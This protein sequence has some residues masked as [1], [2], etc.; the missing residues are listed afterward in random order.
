MSS[1]KAALESDTR[2]LA[3]EAGRKHQVR[4]NTISAGPLG[5]R[6]AK[7]IGFID[8]MIRWAYHPPFPPYKCCSCCG[9]LQSHSKHL[10]PVCLSTTR[11]KLQAE[12][13]SLVLLLLR[14]P[15]RGM[16][17]ATC[18]QQCTVRVCGLSSIISLLYL[19][20][21]ALRKQLAFACR[22]LDSTQ[23]LCHKSMKFTCRYSYENA[24]IQ[25]ELQA[26]EVGNAAAFLLSPLA[27][28]IT[29]TTL[30]VDNGLNCMGMATDSQALVR[31]EAPAK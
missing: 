4:V 22:Q 10:V 2:V 17:I 25:K 24:P 12:R 3:Y 5:S 11:A 13:T 16:L 31:A 21:S 29:G 20:L 28:A 30:Y 1:A 18:N 23:P 27:S 14:S 19:E 9:R 15:G 26:R 6:A 8:D 7:A